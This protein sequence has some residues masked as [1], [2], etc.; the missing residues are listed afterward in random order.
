MTNLIFKMMEIDFEKKAQDF[1]LKT[2]IC[3]FS[4]EKIAG[5]MSFRSYFRIFLKSS[6]MQ[7][8]YKNINTILQFYNFTN[9]Q[10]D[11]NMAFKNQRPTLIL[12]YAPPNLE[13]CKPFI[14]IGNFLV[15]NGFS[16]P[17]IY[18]FDE[19][20][21]FLLLEDLGDLT[22][23][24]FLQNH[25]SKEAEFD[26]YKKAVDCLIEIQEKKL[27]QNVDFYNYQLLFK[28]VNLFA[29]YYVKYEKN[30]ELNFEQ[31][32]KFKQIWINLFD[33][34]NFKDKSLVL[35]D[36]HADNLMFL[37]G[38]ENVAQ[39]GLLDFQDAVIGSK[40]YDLVSLLEDIRRK[41]DDELVE[42]MLRYYI[43]NAK[44]DE[45]LFLRDYEILS[46]QRNIKIMGIISRV[47]RL[48]KKPHYHYLFDI[49]KNLI[50]KRIQTKS[51]NLKEISTFLKEYI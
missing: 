34:L 22:F 21:G 18:A 33:K 36:Y 6:K 51:E 43:K 41:V 20:N 32:K 15:E 48:Y 29:D 8:N 12:M 24:K 2:G 3:D 19:E 13:D 14:N 17:K 5:D 9:L 11:I 4:L 1:L 7:E 39:V 44:I 47:I 49:T 42:K 25:Y 31:R 37:K 16:A 35:R 28:E 27:P 30:I 50:L 26:L 45:E 38:R 10:K 40:A 23:N 46:L